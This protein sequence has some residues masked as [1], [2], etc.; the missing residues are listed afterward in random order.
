[1]LNDPLGKGGTGG[2]GF[3]GVAGEL[4]GDVVSHIQLSA[5]ASAGDLLAFG[6][7]RFQ[8]AS[9]PL[10]GLIPAHVLEHQ[11]AGKQHGAG[12]GLVLTGVLGSGAVGGFEHGCPVAD[13]GA[14]GQADAAGHGGRRVGEVIAVEVR[15]GDDAVFI[16]PKLNLLKHAVG[17]AVLDNQPA[18]GVAGLGAAAL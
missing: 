2:A 13:V 8:S 10:G 6:E 11:D 1:M 15:R 14:G 4:A 3:G 17:N 16:R 5:G 7:S 12:I 18:A 9:D